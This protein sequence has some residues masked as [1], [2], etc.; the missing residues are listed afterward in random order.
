MGIIHESKRLA[1][2]GRLP[3]VGDPFPLRYALRNLDGVGTLAMEAFCI[4]A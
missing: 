2:V 1:G 3:L 4:K